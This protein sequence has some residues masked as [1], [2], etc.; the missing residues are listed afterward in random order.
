MLNKKK[1]KQWYFY[2][3]FKLIYVCLHLLNKLNIKLWC[4]TTLLEDGGEGGSSRKGAGHP[5]TPLGK[6][7]VDLGGT[8]QVI[9]WFLQ[10]RKNKT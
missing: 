10:L 6:V 5:P 2:T 1:K 3:A 8:A 4:V 7:L 9:Q